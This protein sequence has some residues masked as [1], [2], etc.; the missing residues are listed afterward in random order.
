[1]HMTVN[2]F[3]FT[4]ILPLGVMRT[5]KPCSQKSFT[6]FISINFISSITYVSTNL[7]EIL[8]ELYSII[9]LILTTTSQILFM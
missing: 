8:G 1:M 7:S 9:R 4:K 6:I 3:F 2:G 5:K